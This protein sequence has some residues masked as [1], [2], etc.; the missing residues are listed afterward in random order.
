[1]L[2]AAVRMGTLQGVKTTVPENGEVSLPDLV[3]QQ[4]ELKPGQTLVWERLAPTEFLVRVEGASEEPEVK[5]DPVAALGFAKKHGLPTGT[6]D[7]W[8]RLI[9]PHYYDEEE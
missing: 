4:M 8:M 3:R 9:R 7:E 2:P 1:M 5:P 6:T